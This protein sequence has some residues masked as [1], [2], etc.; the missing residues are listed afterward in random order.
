M[1]KGGPALP[2]R[3]LSDSR[4]G[5]SCDAR[6]VQSPAAKRTNLGS[7]PVI[8]SRTLNLGTRDA[9]LELLTLSDIPKNSGQSN[10]RTESCLPMR[11]YCG[12]ARALTF[13][14]AQNL[15]R[16]TSPEPL[17]DS[18]H[19]IYAVSAVNHEDCADI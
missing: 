15:L 3:V 14:F 18:H 6:A 13:S 2:I 8:K 7:T 10:H 5:S 17:H 11:D 19:D 9:E 1:S 4:F 16:L 12:A